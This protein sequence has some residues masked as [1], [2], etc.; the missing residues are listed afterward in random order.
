[1]PKAT[2]L[3]PVAQVALR[4]LVPSKGREA[5][6]FRAGGLAAIEAELR[7]RF[8]SPDLASAVVGLIGVA[9]HLDEDRGCKA[10]AHALLGIATNATQPIRRLAEQAGAARHKKSRALDSR[11]KRFADRPDD[12]AR[13]PWLGKGAPA[14]AVSLSTLAPMRLK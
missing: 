10:A 1:M 14:G 2:E 9:R 13:A 4:Q 8:G 3:H 5:F 11:F 6:A 7:V 12:A